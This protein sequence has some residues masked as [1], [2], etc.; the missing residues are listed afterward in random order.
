MVKIRAG[1]ADQDRAGLLI[2][3]SWFSDLSSRP[4]RNVK[5]KGCDPSV[6]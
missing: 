4:K 2:L 6:P 3:L 5:R 1:I